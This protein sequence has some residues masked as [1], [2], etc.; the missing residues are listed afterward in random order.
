MTFKEDHLTMRTTRLFAT[1]M[2]DIPANAEVVSHQLLL[3][4]GFIRLVTSGVYNY[5]PLMCRVIQNIER[6]VREEMN[7]S[8]AQ[9][10]LLAAMQP[11][12]LWET[13]GR[14]ENYGKELFR[15]KDRHDRDTCLAPTAEE[16]VTHLSASELP[17]YRNMPANV[18]QI[19]TKFRDEVRPRFGLLRGREFIMKDAYSFH[20]SEECLDNEYT[21][22]AEAYTRMF[23]R[24]GLETKM[25]RSDSGAIGGDTSHEFMVITRSDES[26]QQ[27]GEND[28]VHC[29][30]CDYAANI[31]KAEG[32][33][34][35]EGIDGQAFGFNEATI[36]PTKKTTTIEKLTACLNIPASLI[37]KTLFYQVNETQPLLVCLRGDRRIEDTK[38]KVLLPAGAEIRLASDEE[39]KATFNT[40]K[41]FLGLGHVL[42]AVAPSDELQQ[43]LSPLSVTLPTGER[44]PVLMDSTLSPLKRFVIAHN[45]YDEHSVGVE[46][47]TALHELMVKHSADVT[48]VSA[49]DGC[50]ECGGE[51]QVSRGIEVGNI[52]KLGKKYTQAMDVSYTSEAGEKEYALMGC[53]GI[54]I[55]RV[56]AAVVEQLHD[57]NGIIW[58]MALAPYKVCIVTANTHDETQAALGEDLYQQLSAVYQD[59]VLLDDRNERAG[60]KFKDADLMGFPIRITVG[61][62]AVEGQVEVLLRGTKQ[63]ELVPM[64]DV[65]NRVQRL[66]DASI[67]N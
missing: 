66:I 46:W 24:C 34:S 13:S 61:K 15:F 33:P 3:R 30:S 21:V 14:W 41:G 22:M 17:S 47:P 54:G 2:R 60:V 42:E 64:D 12:T 32:V 29:T 63:T 35:Q 11:A 50:I 43:A 39:L 62:H 23:K 36:V 49:G 31:E 38:L 9:E 10:L 67:E 52:F 59:D 48:S 18:Y 28:V 40:I 45:K 53:Y 44:I 51:L 37:V 56:A 6:I 57:E 1:T 20:S 55:T 19:S 25:V 7:A 4:A 8:G 5:L 65:L 58:P 26:G 16:I 27:S